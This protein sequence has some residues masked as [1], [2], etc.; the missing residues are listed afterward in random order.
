MTLRDL[1]P[2]ARADLLKGTSSYPIIA[3]LRIRARAAVG[4]LAYTSDTVS[5][6]V[7]GVLYRPIGTPIEPPEEAEVTSARLDLS[8]PDVDGKI[9]DAL[10]KTTD[11]VLVSIDW[12]SM[13]GF[14]LTAR[15]RVPDGATPDP[16]WSERDWWVVEVSGADGAGINLT[17]APPDIEQEPFP[18][19]RATADIAPGLHP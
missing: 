7:D 14:D 1:T 8:L 11:R 13:E 2:G 3:Y 6:E 17:I 12:H 15:P 10:R 9:G 19:L 18:A 16:L 5:H 4:G